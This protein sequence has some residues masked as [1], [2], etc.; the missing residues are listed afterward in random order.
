MENDADIKIKREK[1]LVAVTASM[2]VIIQIFDLAMSA[3]IIADATEKYGKDMI[4][5]IMGEL[6]ASGF[7]N[8]LKTL[9]E[10]IL[11]QRTWLN[12]LRPLPVT[13]MKTRN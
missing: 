1:A 3:E 6:M 7:T 8:D 11:Q 12:L 9:P 4:D 13:W 2:A 10:D 5:T